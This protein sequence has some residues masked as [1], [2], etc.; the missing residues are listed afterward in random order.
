MSEEDLRQGSSRCDKQGIV[1]E[2]E[3]EVEEILDVRGRP[4]KRF[5][6]CD[7]KGIVE[8]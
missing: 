5:F 1:D 6:A 7:G 4:E 3:F 8:G 2:E